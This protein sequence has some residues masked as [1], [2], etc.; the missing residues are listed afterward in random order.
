M[1]TSKDG[2]PSSLQYTASWEPREEISRFNFKVKMGKSSITVAVTQ[3]YLC[4]ELCNV[5]TPRHKSWVSLA[6]EIV[7]LFLL[8]HRADERIQAK[9]QRA[10]A[11]LREWSL[12]LYSR[13][14][15]KIKPEKS[16]DQLLGGKEFLEEVLYQKEILVLK[17]IPSSGFAFKLLIDFHQSF[18]FVWQVYL[19]QQKSLQELVMSEAG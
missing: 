7:P 1:C 18:F 2:F 11:S 13:V 8:S 3:I 4:K 15:F 14:Y 17:K 6:P 10:A 12:K 5:V 9:R 19:W 16:R